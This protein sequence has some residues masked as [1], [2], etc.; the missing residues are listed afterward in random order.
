MTAMPLRVYGLVDCNNFYVSCER[1]FDPRLE[2]V[3][4][5]VLSNNDGCF[6]ARSAELKA[7]GVTMGQPLF[8]VRDL[9]RRHHV[10]V[11]SS[12]YALYG[13]LSARV[14]DCLRGFTPRLEVYPSTNRSWTCRASTAGTCTP[15]RPKSGARFGAGPGSRPVSASVPQRPS[16]R[17]PTM[18]RKRR[19]WTT[20][21]CATWAPRRSG[22]MSCGSCRSRTSG[23]SAD[24]RPK[25]SGC[26]GSRPRRTCGTWNPAALANCSPSSASALSTS[27][28]GVL[29]AA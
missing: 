2:G 21:A 13:D 18:G 22:S 11:L 20:P 28:G 17:S 9:V 1:V 23:A 16:P 10:R 24:A 25:S 3:P 15:M 8:E 19:C 7:L 29:S 12:N 14:T 26:S 4:V 5:G 27:C 6:V